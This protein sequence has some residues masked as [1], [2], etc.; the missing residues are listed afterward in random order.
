MATDAFELFKEQDFDQE[1][2]EKEAAMRPAVVLEKKQEK[3]NQEE[4]E[5]TVTE[6]H[7]EKKLYIID[8]YGLIYRSYYGFFNNPIKDTQGNNVS[9]VY[10]FFSTLLK[11]LRENHP[12]YLVVAMDSHGP[13][14]RHEMYEPY[15]ANREAAPEDLHAQVPVINKLLK[16]LRIPSIGIVGFEADDIIAT[17]SEEAT[18]HGIDTIMFTGDKDLLQLVDDHTFALR[19]AKKNEK[20]YRLMGD[21]EVLEEFGIAPKQIVDY[22]SLLGDSSDNVPGVKGIGEKGAVK[23]L[24]QFGNLEE[25]YKNLRLCAKG[26]QSKLEEGRSNALLSKALV[27]L[28]R[29]LFIVDSFDTP[30]YLVNDVDYDAAIPLFDEIGMKSI[31]RELGR[32]STSEEPAKKLASVEIKGE[33]K[34]RKGT[35]EAV[36]MLA[37]LKELFQQA[38]KAGGVI[39]FDLETTSIDEM[40]ATPVGFSFSWVEGIAYYVPIISEG[41]RMFEDEEI[42]AILNE[43]LP[44]GRLA[45]VGQNIKYD[46]KVLM[47]WGIEPKTLVF[48]TMVAAWLLDSTGVFNM[49][50]LSEKY[51][52]YKTVHYTDVVPKGKLISDIPQSQAVFYGA[53]DSDIT[54][55]LYKLFSELLL[56]RNLKGVMEEIEMPLLRIIADMELAGIFLDRNLIEPL[57]EE[58]E[59]RIAVIQK[60]IFAIC[61]HEFNINSPLQLQQVLFVEREIPTGAKT[62]S[63]F[64]TATEVLE[65][66]SEMYPE[67]A[68]VLQYR[69]LNKLKNTYID[70]LPLEINEKTNRVHPSFLQT[71]TE[72]GR[73]SCKNPN[74]QNIPVR[75]E[76]GRRIR[77]AFV[78]KQGCIFLSADYA[79]IELVVLAHMADDPGL[80][81]AF[82]AG[83]DVHKA[84]ASLIFNVPLD[85]VS[86]DQRR[87]A[88][89][90]NFGV[91]YGMSAH[92]LAGDLKITHT[93]AKQFID[94]YFDRYSAVQAFVEKT[95]I[96]AEKDGYV[97]TL[98]GHVRTITEIHSQN[99]VEQAKAQRISVNTVIQGS[100]ADIMKMAMLRISKALKEHSL[101]ATLLLQIHD[102]LIFEVPQEEVETVHALVKEAMEG[103][104]KL[105]LPLKTSI[106]TG[107]SWG[108]I[109]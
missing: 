82:L 37:R 73:L 18:R 62:R 14:F 97:T 67:V 105:S 58:F 49:D 15:K 28:K 98:L 59:G 53:E 5:D 91:M 43:Y 103:A 77:S 106:E 89:T 46:Y 10:G 45:L 41:I 107:P 86:S 100:A 11:L 12:D 83:E 21:K 29:D 65:P 8:G 4:T 76:E 108:D 13:T 102:E 70:K 33:E 109:H 16:A 19:P 32:I 78:P 56:A 96:R 42:K 104:V 17:L 2:L 3:E 20:H 81:S 30:Q 92:S 63:G 101:K 88:K 71:G 36:V 7:A 31:V 64:S 61:G 69:A 1:K 48:D 51:L 68:L 72:T 47:N 23:L 25:I 38:E 60:E 75:T 57:T 87:I 99:R 90:I 35:Y 74:L 54:F 50:Y 27:E 44:T 93:E 66:L 55:R 95:K 34:A 22:L 9:A 80:K 84:T 39:A 6:S 94:Q 79:Q 24:Q 26:I 40:T 85:Q 52:N